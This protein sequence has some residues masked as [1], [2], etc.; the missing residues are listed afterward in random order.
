MSIVRMRSVGIQR[1]KTSAGLHHLDS[2]IQPASHFVRRCTADDPDKF[3][4]QRPRSMSGSCI[5]R[6]G[7]H[8]LYRCILRCFIDCGVAYIVDG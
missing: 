8:H 6:T 7:I 5:E 4:G 2:G 1:V 3:A